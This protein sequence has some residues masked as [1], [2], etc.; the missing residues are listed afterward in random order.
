M[1]RN[2]P[3]PI[4]EF[5]VRCNPLA[6]NPFEKFITESIRASNSIQNSLNMVTDIAEQWDEDTMRQVRAN[7]ILD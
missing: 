2:P 7:L 1:G 4:A 3:R 5:Y 6:D